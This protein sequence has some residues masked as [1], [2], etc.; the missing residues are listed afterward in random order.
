LT[1]S[2]VGPVETSSV[3]REMFA[4]LLPISHSHPPQI[5]R[6]IK[7]PKKGH[8][9]QNE[10]AE[11]ILHIFTVVFHDDLLLSKLLPFSVTFRIASS[12][13]FIVIMEAFM[14]P[15]IEITVD[16][17]VTTR[18]LHAV[19]RAHTKLVSKSYSPTNPIFME[20]AP[21]DT[22]SKAWSNCLVV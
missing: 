12:I 6:P 19:S 5:L 20:R 9:M 21:V 4:F 18:R 1:V 11:T 10:I 13:I 22:I 16:I 3:V 14:L 8:D 7:I 2:I 17:I 15:Y